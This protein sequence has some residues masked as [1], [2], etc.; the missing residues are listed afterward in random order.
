VVKVRKK[1][2]NLLEKDEKLL[3]RYEDIVE[4]NKKY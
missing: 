3:E 2:K 4:K 1:I